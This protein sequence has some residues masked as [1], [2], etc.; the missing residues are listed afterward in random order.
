M[1]EPVSITEFQDR[2]RTD[3]DCL[4]EIVRKRWPSG[5]SCPHCAST[6]CSKLSKRRAF[7]CNQ[8]KK[9]TSITAGT[10]FE[11]TRIPLRNW[12]I[13]MYLIANDKGGASALRLTTLLDMRYDTVWHIV[14]KLRSAMGEREQI[15]QLGGSIE[16]DEAFFGGADK[17][18]NRRGRASKKKV[19]VLVMVESQGDRAGMLK[20]E[21]LENGFNMVSVRSAVEPRV[22]PNQFFE[23]DGSGVYGIL[24]AFGHRVTNRP[25]LR[26]EKDV[27][28]AW[29]NKAISLAKRFI[30]G[31]YHG[32]SSKHLQHY[33]DE[34]CFRWNRRQFKTGLFMRMLA[35]ALW[36]QP[37]HYDALTG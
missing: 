10:I 24:S 4:A 13:M 15:Y 20:M 16:I 35:T 30:L 7:Q 32:V 37:I 11:K 12:F 22:A 26:K 1:K 2:F 36:S 9:Q 17:G 28:L 18:G 3:D 34:F 6:H 8:C 21:I 33:L 19:S 5:F 25:T 27:R 23:A 14:Q 31:T 29:V